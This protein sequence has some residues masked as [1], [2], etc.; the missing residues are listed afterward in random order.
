MDHYLVNIHFLS[1]AFGGA[2]ILNF[3]I[4]PIDGTALFQIIIYLPIWG[5][6]ENLK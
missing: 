6:V 1:E 2:R 4:K 5:K 3:E